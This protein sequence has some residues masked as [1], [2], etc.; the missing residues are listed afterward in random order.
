MT[1]VAAAPVAAAAVVP[2]ATVT[3]TESEES[4]SRAWLYALIGLAVL[5]VVLLL[6]L[7]PW[8]SLRQHP[9]PRPDHAHA[10][11]QP[12]R[13]HR[14]RR[15]SPSPSPTPTES[16]TPQVNVDPG[17]YVGQPVDDVRAD[18]RAL[19]LQTT[20]QTVDNPGDQDEGTVAGLSPT[21][22][23]D[24]GSTITLQVYGPAPDAPTK[25]KGPGP[26]KGPTRVL[27]TVPATVRA[28]AE[29]EAEGR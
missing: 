13:P 2:P 27:A 20:T 6:V 16:Q 10:L 3:T 29:R 17:D 12:H 9:G 7:R 5:V 19:G 1:G 21:G 22:K 11:G 28:T 18:L 23:V 25:S 26:G 15:E 4:G 8:E 14:R 24:Q